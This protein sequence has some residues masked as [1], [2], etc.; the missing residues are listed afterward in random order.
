MRTPADIAR[1]EAERPLDAGLVVG[2]DRHRLAQLLVEDVAAALA[3][4]GA[5]GRGDAEGGD[6][7][8][9]GQSMDGH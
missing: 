6:R 7:G 2:T 9:E 4:A 8:D 3:I 1:F 5:A